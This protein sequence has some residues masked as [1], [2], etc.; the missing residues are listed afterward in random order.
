MIDEH[1]CSINHFWKPIFLRDLQIVGGFGQGYRSL[2]WTFHTYLGPTLRH[3]FREPQW[4]PE[5][6][7]SHDVLEWH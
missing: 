4:R 2:D 1:G 7:V 6:S 5:R 3:P